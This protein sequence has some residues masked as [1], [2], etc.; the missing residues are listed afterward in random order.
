MITNIAFFIFGAFSCFILINLTANE[1]G[2][3]V[4]WSSIG[5]WVDPSNEELI[6]H[7]STYEI[8]YDKELKL[9]KLVCGGEKPKEHTRYTEAV[10]K[11]NHE[12]NNLQKYGITYIP[13]YINDKEG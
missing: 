7:R 10:K 2:W 5:E 1:S 9:L 4:I 3:V 8:R 11:F 12:Y 13:N 6:L